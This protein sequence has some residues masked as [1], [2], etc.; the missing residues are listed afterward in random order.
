MM[1]SGEYAKE[2]QYVKSCT[3]T[4]ASLYPYQTTI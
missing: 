4:I 3:G 2:D 1:S